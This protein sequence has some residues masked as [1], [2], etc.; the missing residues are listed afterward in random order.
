[1]ID[2]L[3]DQQAEEVPRGRCGDAGQ[4]CKQGMPRQRALRCQRAVVVGVDT[5]NGVHS[6]IGGRV[7]R[8]AE[9]H[10]RQQVQGIAVRPGQDAFLAE[11]NAVVEKAKADGSL[12]AIHEKWLGTPL[13]EHVAGN[14][15]LATSLIAG[16]LSA[17]LY[18]RYSK[19]ATVNRLETGG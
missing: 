16:S 6:A 18:S 19:H 1:M 17:F 7:R 5:V 15:F 3:V 8:E 11:I 9:Q 14:L 13:P 4:P 2:T 12:N 10:R